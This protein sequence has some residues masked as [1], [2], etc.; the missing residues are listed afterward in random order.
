MRIVLKAFDGFV[1]C[2]NAAGSLWILLVTVLINTDVVARFGFNEPV[3]GVPLVITMSLIAIVFLQLPDALLAGRLTRNDS[4]LGKL[5][6]ERPK[7]GHALQA[8]YHAAGLMLMVLLVQFSGPMFA[9]AWTSDAFLGS[10]GDFTL[11]EWPFKLLIVVGSIA[12]GLQFLRLTWLDLRAIA[13][14]PNEGLGAAGT[15]AE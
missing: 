2:M 10:R 13:G 14:K 12:V 3:R 9:K 8:L 4:L 15:H 5:L 11:P 7:I 1:R 6:L